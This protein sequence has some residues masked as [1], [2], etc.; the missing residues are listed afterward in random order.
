MANPPLRINPITVLQLTVGGFFQAA[1]ESLGLEVVAGSSGLD[2]PI[3]EPVLHRPGLA[4][5]GYYEF[6]AWRRPQVLG[7]AEAAYLRTLGSAEGV[8]RW[9][10]L[11]KRDVPCVI[12]CGRD[13][14]AVGGD[15]LALADQMGI[16]ILVTRQETLEVFRLGSVL[17]HE[18]TAPRV[19][20]IGTLVDVDGVGVLLEGP[21]GIGKSETALGLMRRGHAL[22]SDDMTLLSVD[23]HGG[24]RGTSKDRFRGYMEI[25]GLGL[26]PVEQLFGIAAVKSEC[27]LDLIISL[28]RCE[29]EDDIDRVG[30]DVQACEVLGQP[31]QRMTIPVAA[32]RDFVNVVE[33][34]AATFKLRRSGVD[35]SAILDKQMISHFLHV[36]Q[37]K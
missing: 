17:L 7:R 36:E 33:T 23:A 12:L 4:L 13:D 16:P 34:A 37:D 27:R 1:L 20:I 30:S 6:F 5:T 3:L 18:L 8:A 11:L 29:T 21:P 24:V 14:E 28:R 31:I 15:F 22:I 32:G 10:A 35:P 2:R 19:S 9:E 26:L 25:R